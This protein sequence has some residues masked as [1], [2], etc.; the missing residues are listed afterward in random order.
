MSKSYKGFFRPK[1]PSKYKGDP[2]GIVFRSS[3][4]LK[5]MLYLDAHPDVLEWSSEE[6]A[7]PYRSPVDGRI[8]RYF[9]D[10]W[11]KQ[12]NINGDI[13]TIVVEI[14]PKKQTEPPVVQTRRTKR[15]I[16][17][18]MTWGVN[19]A[20]WQAA[21]EYCSERK[22]KFRIFTEQHLGI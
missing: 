15:Y 10:F 5:F 1:N 22:W 8:H 6:F 19:S 9:P 3:W 21:E 13:E 14:K 12:K 16:S 20:K 2:S 7:I 11:V 4:E 17:E 18:V